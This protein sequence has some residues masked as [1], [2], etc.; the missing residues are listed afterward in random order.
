VASELTL[1]I[2]ELTRR[3]AE[4]MARY[5]RRQAY[6]STHCYEI[7]RRALEH[8]DE[9]AWAAVYDQYH[10]LV[11][12]QLGNAPGEPDALVNQVFERFWRA[13]PPEQFADFPTLDRLLAYL[14]RCAQSVAM[15]ARRREQRKHVYES[16]LATL[17]NG[18]ISGTQASPADSLLDE[19]VGEQ[20]FEHAREC[21]SGHQERVV[22]RASLEWDLRPATIA[23]R[24][25]D[26]F[27]D[28]RE[29]SRVKERIFRRLQR[30]GEL[31]VL[32]GMSDDDGGKS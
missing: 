1:P 24:W 9:A 26:L 15:D 16:A 6:D 14:K 28:A 32:L 13:I 4:E 27:A 29:V 21:L 12:Y 11:R 7:F 31:R 3:C 22:F 30:D 2:T 17:Q 19:I 20:V 18:I 10:R 25:P 23:E 8:G 5:Q